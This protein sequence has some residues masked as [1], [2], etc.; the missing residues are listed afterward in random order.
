MAILDTVQLLLC[1]IS[2]SKI[3]PIFVVL[4]VQMVTPLTML[5]TT[6]FGRDVVAAHDSSSQPEQTSYTTSLRGYTTRQILGATLI[7]MAVFV[8]LFPAVIEIYYPSSSWT[9]YNSG[10]NMFIFL[11][12]CVPAA[13]STLYK[14]YTLAEYKLPVSPQYLN[15]VLAI[16][17]VIFTAIIS[18]LV[19]PLQGFVQ[20]SNWIDLYPSSD[21][22]KNFVDSMQCFVSS[23]D[24]EVATSQYAE[25]ADCHFIW[26]LLVGYVLSVVVSGMAV[27]KV[28]KG[29]AY[30][31]LYRGLSFGVIL[32]MW[33]MW[34]YDKNYSDK[35]FGEVD[36]YANVSNSLHLLSITV[37]I[38]GQDLY[39]RDPLSETSFE[40]QYQFVGDVGD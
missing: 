13:L 28:I 21:I 38:F 30:N 24:E 37:L 4:L 14:E 2:G 36:K 18:P 26:I 39:H 35:S 7:T 10:C 6:C 23:I 29:G 1:V 17:Q 25:S 12:S 16:F 20:D 3:P 22:S 19:Y 11:L 34:Y 31:V 40:T 9:A 27:D 5:L 32:A 8:G 33:S 15:F